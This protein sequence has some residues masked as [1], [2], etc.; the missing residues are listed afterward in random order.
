MKQAILTFET[1]QIMLVELQNDQKWF[2]GNNTLNQWFIRISD[3]HGADIER[4]PAQTLLNRPKYLGNLSELTEEQARDIVDGWQRHFPEQHTVYRN[5]EKPTEYDAIKRS[6]EQKWGE[7]FGKAVESF[8]SKL[9]IEGYFTR[10]PY[11]DMHG[12]R[13]VYES[14]NECGC[15]VNGEILSET[16][17]N[18][19]FRAT[20]KRTFKPSETYVFKIIK[21]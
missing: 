10:N 16:E 14:I 19:K 6:S 7:P 1:C 5:Y 13:V 12:K 17:L 11:A 4:I 9:K 8:L 18:Q 20:A 15:M 2:I 3:R 21:Q